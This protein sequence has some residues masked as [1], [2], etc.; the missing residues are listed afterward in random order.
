MLSEF[1]F[2]ASRVLAC[3]LIEKFQS[4]TVSNF[5]KKCLN[6]DASTVLGFAWPVIES[7]SQLSFEVQLVAGQYIFISL[8][9]YINETTHATKMQHCCKRTLSFQK[10]GFGI[11][12]KWIH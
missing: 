4:N 1:E 11:Y 10:Y 9:N 2:S 8:I 6:P 12:S 5:A 3:A 7:H